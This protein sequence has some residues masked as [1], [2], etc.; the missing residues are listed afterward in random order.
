MKNTALLI[1]FFILLPSILHAWDNVRTHPDLS[2]MATR[3]SSVAGQDYLKNIGLISGIEE[4][5]NSKEIY[6]WLREG[7]DK[8]DA[9][10][11]WQAVKGQARFN[12]H[13]YN[14]R[15]PLEISG[16]DDVIVKIVPN[17]IP[18]FT[19]R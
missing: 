15:K 14:P 10:N 5:V 19:L 4:K 17:P 9:G 18:P 3:K 13:F 12:N 11:W 6:K 2:E 8:E 7:A 16:L 1:I